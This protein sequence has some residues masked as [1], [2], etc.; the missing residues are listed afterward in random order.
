MVAEYVTA[1]T[2]TKFALYKF[3]N[4]YRTFMEMEP[5]WYFPNK[6][7]GSDQYQGRSA[8][9]Y[10]DV[11]GNTAHIYL[12]ATNNGYAAYTMTIGSGSAV[13][14][15]ESVKVEAKKVIENGNIFILKNGVK[16]NALGAQVK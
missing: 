4:D 2:S 10:V 13:E 3:D 8:V 16:Y 1:Q 12:Y 15:V 9:P 7:M 14:D 5:L 11:V 6:G